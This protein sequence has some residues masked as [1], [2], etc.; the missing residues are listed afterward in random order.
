VLEHLDD[1]EVALQTCVRIVKSGG[2]LALAVPN[3]DSYQARWSR[4]AWFHLDLPRHYSHFSAP[5]LRSRLAELGFRTVYD[6][7]GSLEQNPYGWIQSILNRWGIRFNLLYDM[8]RHR[9]A[10]TTIEPWR[11]C[12]V[13][14]LL[15]VLGMFCLLPFSF[16][17]LIPEIVFR[18]G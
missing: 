14:S 7:H 8:L 13:Q 12:P 2:V 5:W 6:F 10:R 18:R 9:S 11:E 16:A 3:F 1:A 17:M 15:S 4:Y